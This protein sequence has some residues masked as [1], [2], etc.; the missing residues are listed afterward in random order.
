MDHLA[1]LVNSTPAYYYLLPLHFTLV[2]RYAPFI[3]NL[4]LATEVP[5]HPICAQVAKDHG[6]TLIPLDTRDAGFLASRAAA[7]QQLTLSGKFLHVIPVQEDFLIDRVPDFGALVEA[8]TIVEDSQGLIASA[9]LMPCPGPKGATMVTRPLWAGLTPGTDEYG[10][11]FQAT[12]WSLDA[13]YAWYAALVKKLELEWPVATTSPE[14][15]KHVEIR[16]NFAENAEGQQFFWKF[17]KKRRQVHIGW[18]RSGPWSNAVYLSPW[19]YRPTAI[20][21]GRLEP[22]AAELGKREGVP[23]ILPVSRSGST[24][25]VHELGRGY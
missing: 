16:A 18:V 19:P 11:T 3:E 13:C 10:F 23:L 6:V 8:R 12:L 9:R 21:Q 25:S 22:W 4:F 2:K 1:Y 5:E 20:V 14:Q 17:F 7:L 24:D 15:R